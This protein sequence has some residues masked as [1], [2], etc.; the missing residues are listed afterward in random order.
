VKT[1]AA[2]A[3]LHWVRG[4]CR[5]R[6]GQKMA[7]NARGGGP[8]RSAPRPRS[9]SSFRRT[10]PR[11]A[12]ST[13]SGSRRACRAPA[14]PLVSAPRTSARRVRLR[15]ARLPAAACGTR[16]LPRAGGE[17]RCGG[18]LSHVAET[19]AATSPRGAR[20]RG[21]AETIACTRAGNTRRAQTS[22]SR[23]PSREA[24]GPASDAASGSAG[25]APGPVRCPHTACHSAAAAPTSQSEN[26]AGCCSLQRTLRRPPGQTPSTKRPYP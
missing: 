12:P 9:G 26:T 21:W 4:P 18:R 1:R 10:R 19:K 2:A 14:R 8:A 17:L 6:T 5:A 11:C 3:R 7:Q 20:A 25:W 16:R 22:V 24:D 15:A 13:L 23:A